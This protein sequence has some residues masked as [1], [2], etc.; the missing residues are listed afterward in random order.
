M[1][2]E[3][4]E[5]QIPTSPELPAD[6][7]VVRTAKEFSGAMTLDLG[8]WEIKKCMTIIHEVRSKHVAKFIRKFNEPS[9]FKLDDALKA[10]DEYEDELKTRM[11][12]EVNVLVSVNA[13]PVL[14]GEPLQIEWLGVLPGGTLDKYG[15][16]HERK[17]WE[18][19]RASE[20]GEDYLGQ[21]DS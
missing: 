6:S 3:S 13:V 19:K 12:N 10:I 11:A 21:R 18:V 16:D 20:R 9:A 14:E 15:Q 4:V 8:D 2:D 1:S 17:G 5:V 7:D